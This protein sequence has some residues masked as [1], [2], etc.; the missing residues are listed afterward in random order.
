MLNVLMLNVFMLNVFM[1]NVIM[2]NV[3]MLSV[4]VP[5]WACLKK[6]VKPRFESTPFRSTLRK[7]MN[8]LVRF[9]LADFSD[10]F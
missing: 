6:Y 2:L 4:M 5:A 9:A 7:N 3:I 8:K 1:L 10:P